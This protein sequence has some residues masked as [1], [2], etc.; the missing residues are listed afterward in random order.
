[1]WV[2][3]IELTNIKSCDSL[4]VRLQPGVNLIA[5]V[6]GA[7]KTTL[8][9]C[10]GYA[11]FDQAPLEKNIADYFVRTGEREGSMRV[12]FRTDTG[13]F[14]M[15]RVLR[16][17]KAN[18]V[19]WKAY[20]LSAGGQQL[21]LNGQTDITDW[22]KA[23]MGVQSHVSLKGMFWDVI[24]VSQGMFTAPFLLPGAERKSHFNTILQVEHYKKSAEKGREVIAHIN[25]SLARAEGQL[26]MLDGAEEALEALKSEGGSLETEATR[27]RDAVKKSEA[28]LREAKEEL[29]R[30]TAR[31]RAIDENKNA[32]AL[33]RKT[34]DAAG[35][36]LKE[37]KAELARGEEA[38]RRL[39]ELEPVRKEYAQ[40]EAELARR[41]AAERTRRSLEADKKW[42]EDAIAA[43]TEREKAERALEAGARAQAELEKTKA[44]LAE[45]AAALESTG[46][47]LQAAREKTGALEKGRELLIKSLQTIEEHEAALLPLP[48]LQKEIQ[49]LPAARK[50]AED[51]ARAEAVAETRIKQAERDMER[52]Q[53]GSCP[54]MGRECP[55]VGA[56]LQAYLKEM[57]AGLEREL[58]VQRQKVAAAQD[59][60][61]RLQK[62]SDQV[63]VLLGRQ[64]Q[65]QEAQK[66]KE[67]YISLLNRRI[68]ELAAELCGLGENVPELLPV[69]S[70][71]GLDAR[72]QSAGAFLDGI[73]QD[74]HAGQDALAKDRDVYA[75]G[76][77]S[78]AVETGAARQAAEDADVRL[79]DLLSAAPELSDMDAEAL[80]AALAQRLRAIAAG[81]AEIVSLSEL[82][83][84]GNAVRKRRDALRPAYEEYIE[85][86]VL[87]EGLATCGETVKE[88]QK[89]RA[90]AAQRL[91]VLLARGAKLAE[92]WTPELP[93]KAQALA[94]QLSAAYYQEQAR[95]RAH[96]DRM[97][98]HAAQ[99]AEQEQRVEELHALTE[100]RESLQ[101]AKRLMDIICSRILRQ[102]GERVS[103][104]Y[105]AALSERAT[106][107]Y[108]QVARQN[109][110]LFWTDDYDIVL[111]DVS[112]GVMRRRT[113]RQL[114]GGEQ[115]TAALAVRLGLLS[116]M[117]EVSMVC[118]DEPTTNLDRRR[119]ENLA[120]MV[121]RL[122]RSFS[123]VLVISHDDTFDALTQNTVRL[124]REHPAPTALYRM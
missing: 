75:R 35:Q 58:Q 122:T 24:G 65:L 37:C 55:L 12:T 97:K 59:E 32:A 119:R 17:G 87:A 57:R 62:A 20:D 66:Q 78:L 29:A 120:Q 105:R 101:R 48:A 28:A 26:Q 68:G 34:L 10:I 90:E 91:D 53:D 113:F 31:A 115:M 93:A 114:S 98:S 111:S 117:G 84:R 36:R 71:A 33:E 3:S 123:Q 110:E 103:E 15:E 109:V 51:A 46:K 102:M 8:V 16:L 52:A 76:E 88:A 73:E 89:A 92:G 63:Q 50:A 86:K 49:A 45:R 118:F 25:T 43:L 121:P 112:N 60:V 6:N 82:E 1:M 54:I 104:V 79:D 95:L 64:K 106:Q 27:M 83:A 67:Q 74:M 21:R 39:T 9:E 80:S 56:D 19:T 85:K 100:K 14:M 4:T 47:R 44:A 38:A 61:R 77:A 81:L 70:L 18:K 22:L 11:L 108:A 30:V 107:L 69:T 99:V 42:A 23:Q 94:D 7:G 5:G 124:L 2:E 96:E 13:H 116:Q 41:D 40:A 72:I